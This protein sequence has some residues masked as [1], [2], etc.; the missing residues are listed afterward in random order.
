MTTEMFGNAINGIRPELIEEAAYIS[1]A[2]V[3]MPIYYC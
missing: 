2:S 3:K 1:P